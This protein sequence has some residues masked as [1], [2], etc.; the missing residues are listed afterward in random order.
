[1]GLMVKAQTRKRVFI[2][3][4]SLIPIMPRFTA[5]Y[6]TEACQKAD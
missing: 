6:E 2:V 3:G 4:V 1:M 5:I